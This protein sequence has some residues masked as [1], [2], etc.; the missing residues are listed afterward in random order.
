[1][2]FKTL[3][4]AVIFLINTTL[5]TSY[6]Q[7]DTPPTLFKPPLSNRIANYDIAATL[8]TQTDQING[9]QILTWKNTGSKATATLQFHLYMNAFR[10]SES[11]YMLESPSEVPEGDSAEIWGYI[12]VHRLIVLPKDHHQP[13][14]YIINQME[15]RSAPIP[16]GTEIT[17]AIRFIHPDIPEHTKDQTVIE[18]SLPKPLAPGD[19][20]MLFFEFTT[21]LPEPPIARTGTFKEF[22]FAGQ[23]FPKIGVWQDSLWNC[24]QFHVN[25]EFFSD[26]GVYNVWIT[27]PRTFLIGATGVPVGAPKPV[28]DSTVQH[29]FH[30]ED[31]HDFAWTASPEF[32]EFKGIAQDVEIHALMQRDHISQGVRHIEAT[33]A[34]IEFFQNNYGDYPYPLVTLVDPHRK[35]GNVGGMEYP[36]L[37]TVGT[38]Y[39]LPEGVRFPELVTIHEFGHNYWQGMVASNEFEESWLDEGINTYT[40]MVAM[41]EIFGDGDVLNYLGIKVNDDHIFRASYL[42]ANDMDPIVK[43]AWEYESR[44]SYGINSYNEPGLLLKSLHNLVGKD[45]MHRIISTYFNKWK[46]KHPTTS[47]FLDVVQQIAGPAYLPFLEQALYT[48]R[49]L[50][51]AVDR[52]YSSPF[53]KQIDS[54]V[55][56]T[57]TATTDSQTVQQDSTTL[58]ESGFTVRRNGDFVFPVE[59]QAVF[60]NGDTLTEHWD[61]KARYRKFSY[62]RTDRI[63][64]ATVDPQRKLLIDRNFTNNSQTLQTDNLGVN[65]LSAR[66]LFWMQFLLDQP[67]LF[68]LIRILAR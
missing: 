25:S 2:N 57:T 23:W 7:T 38:R 53:S 34:A 36:T 10:H 46:F 26:F 29:F 47:D 4:T 42:A 63:I 39:G 18:V 9:K 5:T 21:K 20:V 14:W 48:E 12:D 51:Y 58:Y 52:I 61:G 11:T 35:A 65:K 1:L 50:D 44:R 31:V 3:F 17:D 64:Y 62:L 19:S 6:A 22:Y 32:V 15:E 30:A 56:D 28:T 45:T 60:S 40:E 66:W 59:I 67:E 43:K 41:S 68:N 13:G 8:N 16:S 55:V 54:T 33:K 49:R 27:L 24:H 37:F